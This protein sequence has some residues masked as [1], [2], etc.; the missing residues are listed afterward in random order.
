[1]LEAFQQTDEQLWYHKRLEQIADT[2][3][4]EASLPDR[5]VQRF[6]RVSPDVMVQIVVGRPEAIES[7][8]GDDQSAAPR[9][10]P[11]GGVKHPFRVGH[12]LEHVQ[13]EDRVERLV[14]T[15]RIVELS[16]RDSVAPA[17][18]LLD[19]RGIG[20]DAFDMTKPREGVE[21]QPRSATHI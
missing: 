19:E 12:M 20:F 7:G 10:D 17:S 1:M 8:H 13:H 21:K 16:E 5:V 9:E 18:A 11:A 3:H 14:G 6:S 15:E 4:H 2:F